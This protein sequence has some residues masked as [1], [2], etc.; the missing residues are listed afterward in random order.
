MKKHSIY[1]IILAALLTSPGFS[2]PQFA[3][4]KGSYGIA[5]AAS[6]SSLGDGA[7]GGDR[8]TLINISPSVL[9]FV[10]PGLGLGGTVNYA[11]AS[12]GSSTQNSFGIGP[13]VAYYFHPPSS[14]VF[15]LL[16]FKYL[17]SDTGGGGVVDSNGNS[18]QFSGGA[19]FMISKN[20]GLVSEVFYSY[21]R[22][23]IDDRFGGRFLTDYRTNT[24]GIQLGIDVFV[25]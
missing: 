2:Q 22:Q 9:Y 16:R 25:F 12:S 19:T 5:G 6:F 14:R 21:T 20:I 24:I 8:T 18:F 1:L 15:P 7:L 17:Y 4:D 13:T 3:V 10:L 23:S 11:R